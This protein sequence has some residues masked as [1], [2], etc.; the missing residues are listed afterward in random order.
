M[1]GVN[2]DVFPLW[3]HSLFHEYCPEAY[4]ESV[5]L[6]FTETVKFVL[7]LEYRDHLLLACGLIFTLQFYFWISKTFGF[8][9]SK[10]EDALAFGKSTEPVNLYL[11]R[12]GPH[13]VSGSPY[14]S[15]IALF[16]RLAGIPHTVQQA[17]FGRNPKGKV[18]YMI[19]D[20]EIIG[21]SQL[22]IRYLE[23]TFDVPRMAMVA[24]KKLNKK[25]FISYEKLSAQDKALS[26]AVRLI[27]EG[28]LYWAVV[29]IRWLGKV[30]ISESEE[31]WAATC[32]IYFK[33]YPSFLTSM[34]RGILAG[35]AKSQGLARHSPK[36]QVYLA[37]RALKA[38]SAI[39]G[40]KPYFLGEYP[41][42]CDCMAF[43]QLECLADG[44]TWPNPLTEILQTECQNLVAYVSRMRTTYFADFKEGKDLF[45]GEQLGHM[46]Y[47]NKARLAAA[48]GDEAE[49]EAEEVTTGY[50]PLNLFSPDPVERKEA[51]ATPKKLN[52]SPAHVPAVSHPRP[53]K[54]GGGLGFG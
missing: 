10:S 2:M 23:N 53:V 46:A 52:V 5:F 37:S 48:G 24:A 29:S 21:D 12:S 33:G 42:E 9:I 20:G 4:R 18:P 45:P 47:L 7:L 28:E 11:F 15:K 36:D 13:G 3:M 17:D 54:T 8:P 16:C 40:E 39:L 50:V 44:Q 6:Y 34:I 14:S 1:S 22:I 49:S 25:P 35:D 31:N 19:H 51:L 41:T 32:N 27:C 30:G 26:D 38:L 43:G